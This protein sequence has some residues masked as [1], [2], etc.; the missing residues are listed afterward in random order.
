MSRVSRTDG[1]MMGRGEGKGEGEEV[2]VGVI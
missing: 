1:W 2:V